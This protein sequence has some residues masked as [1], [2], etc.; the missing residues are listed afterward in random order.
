MDI[1]IK[2]LWVAWFLFLM[3]NMFI[4][5]LFP[6]DPD[7]LYVWFAKSTTFAIVFSYCIT[8]IVKTIQA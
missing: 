1:L 7:L 4:A 5:L 6:V 3:F 8:C 2:L